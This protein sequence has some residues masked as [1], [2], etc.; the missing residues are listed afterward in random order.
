MIQG[1]DRVKIFTATN[2]RNREHLGENVTA[3]LRDNP[4]LTL[5]DKRVLQSSDRAFHCISI[6][7]MLR[8]RDAQS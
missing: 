4:N 6:V 1:Y 3:F 8:E 5:V 7:L 2:A